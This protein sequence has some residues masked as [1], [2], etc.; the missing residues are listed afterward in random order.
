MFKLFFIII[1]CLVFLP[2]TVSGKQVDPTRPFG[3]LSQ[4]TEEK[5]GA[6]KIVLQSIIAIGK[7]KKALISGR[8][9]KEGDMFK[10]F[11]VIS[12]DSK[13]VVLES[14]QGKMEL[15]LFSG[16]IAKSQ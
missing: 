6:K 13:G 5:S 8:V 16:V 11:K 14:S 4:P 3:A 15:S 12:I 7:N 1:S 10:E 9:L 2:I